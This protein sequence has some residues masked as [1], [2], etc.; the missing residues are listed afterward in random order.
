MNLVVPALHRQP[1]AGRHPPCSR[2]FA[3]TPARSLDVPKIGF[4]ERVLPNGLEVIA[5]RSST[6]PTISVQVWYHVGA[7]DDPQG[8]SGFAAPVRA[9][10]VKSTKYLKAEQSTG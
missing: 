8:R 3:A 1:R 2:C 5:I 10:D 7:K 9:P 6:S 4:S